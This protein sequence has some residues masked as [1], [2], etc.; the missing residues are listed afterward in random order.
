MTFASS[1]YF[2][3]L[4]LVFGITF[5]TPARFR[6]IILLIASYAF[7]MYWKP[8]YALII[9]GMTLG[10]FFL[11]RAIERSE[12][13][14]SKRAL[15]LLSVSLNLGLLFTFKYLGFFAGQ[16]QLSFP[17]LM[18]PIGL[19][20]HTLQAIGYTTDV[21]RGVIV[22]ERS[23]L[24]FALFIA[25]FP[26]MVAGPIERGANLLPQLSEIRRPAG[27]ELHD[28]LVMIVWGL[29]KKLVVADNLALFVDPVYA[30]P[31]GA[32]PLAAA[33]AV[34]FFALQL[35]FDFS[36]YTDIARGSSEL[37]SVRLV[38]NFDQPFSASTLNEFWRR[39]HMSLS[40]WFFE[41]VYYPLVRR[42]PSGMGPYWSVFAV[43]LLSGLWHGA[44]WT[45]LVWGGLHGLAYGFALY[46]RQRSRVFTFSLVAMLW[47]LFR[48][49]S[50]ENASQVFG[51]LFQWSADLASSLKL[52]ASLNI[53][54]ALIAGVA[55]LA[56]EKW[57]L[58][59]GRLSGKLRD[60]S[61]A[62]GA[63][64]ILVILALGAFSGE[65]FIYFQF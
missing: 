27:P 54:L 62:L 45:F 10:D 30:N 43:F 64:L 53:W 21:Y 2:L 47:V 8:A 60:F 11:A 50:L 14:K 61:P 38:P 4:P 23:L 7:Y 37:F 26:Q 12:L 3:F 35:Y 56:S 58:P 5:S 63:L 46:S 52:D 59:E 19:S 25:W 31:Q 24:R 48:A 39:W 41:Y 42:F 65:R 36:G 1:I 22:A 49:S 6:G 15:W 40:T 16:L 57:L 29:F 18:L 20:F 51:R 32:S 44:N 9:A 28:A 34:L 33:L 55:G 17:S 13:A